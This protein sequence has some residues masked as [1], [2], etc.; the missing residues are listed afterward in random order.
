VLSIQPEDKAKIGIEL[1]VFS[2]HEVFR[3]DNR[4]MPSEKTIT[5]TSYV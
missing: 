3:Q 5:T 2:G 4:M 1:Y